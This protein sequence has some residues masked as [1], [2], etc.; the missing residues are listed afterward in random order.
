[1][2]MTAMHIPMLKSEEVT[3]DDDGAQRLVQYIK[4]RARVLKFYMYELKMP[5][6]ASNYDI[7]NITSHKIINK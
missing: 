6:V 7:Q 2:F 4:D 1:M 5:D 3:L